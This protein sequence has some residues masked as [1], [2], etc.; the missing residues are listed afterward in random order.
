MSDKVGK[1]VKLFLNLSIS[2]FKRNCKQRF[3]MISL[4]F[5]KRQCAKR[6]YFNNNPFDGRDEKG[7]LNAN[8][9]NCSLVNGGRRWPSTSTQ[10]SAVVDVHGTF[11]D[12]LYSKK[13]SKI[14]LETMIFF[15]I[16][17]YIFLL[18]SLLFSWSTLTR[19]LFSIW[20]TVDN[21]CLLPSILSLF[22]HAPLTVSIQWIQYKVKAQSN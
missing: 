14:N 11:H 10:K 19:L 9:E 12:Q 6:Y 1:E 22:H 3:D 15:R 21:R 2:P 16:L 13:C 7:R 4:C 20:S 5:S 18:M 17:K 8:Q